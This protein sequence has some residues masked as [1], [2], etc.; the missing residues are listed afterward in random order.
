MSVGNASSSRLDIPRRERNMVARR[1]LFFGS[2]LLLSCLGLS[3]GATIGYVMGSRVDVTIY[4][5][6]AC[7]PAEPLNLDFLVEQ[8]K[9][10]PD[11]AELLRQY[12]RLKPLVLAGPFQLYLNPTT[13]DFVIQ[14]KGDV[15]PLVI[16]MTQGSETELVFYGNGGHAD[17][18]FTYAKQTGKLLA[19]DFTSRGKGGV[20]GPLMCS[21]MDTTGDGRFDRLVDFQTKQVYEQ[22]GLQWVKLEPG[23]DSGEPSRGA[24]AGPDS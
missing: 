10:S 5:P 3:F 19:S 15:P 14:R 2:V 21:Y 12:R 24:P 23:Q 6:A 22:K 16:Q 7:S 8:A 20:V 17:C 18:S 4:D 11:A 1:L 13:G 9:S